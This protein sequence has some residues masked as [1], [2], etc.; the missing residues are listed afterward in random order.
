MKRQSLLKAQTSGQRSTIEDLKVGKIRQLNTKTE[1]ELT[2]DVTDKMIRLETQLE[3][4]A[5][6]EA[7]EGGQLLQGKDASRRSVFM[8]AKA[9][10]ITIEDSEKKDS[11]PH[12]DTQFKN[13]NYHHIYD[14]LYQD[15]V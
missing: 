3:K 13:K 6:Q 1:Q 8:W 11:K 10:Q 7:K 4:T 14:Q 12:A 5:Q 2:E 15:E 9:K